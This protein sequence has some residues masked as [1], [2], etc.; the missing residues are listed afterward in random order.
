MNNRLKRRGLRGE[1]DLALVV[2]PGWG[3][4]FE[5]TIDFRTQL[6]KTDYGSTEGLP[7]LIGGI[8]PNTVLGLRALQETTKLYEV[9]VEHDPH[10]LQWLARLYEKRVLP[11]NMFHDKLTWG[12]AKALGMLAA[13][14]FCDIDSDGVRLRDEGADFVEEL[15]ALAIT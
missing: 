15:R 12:S 1:E 7:T 4:K 2:P 6:A 11:P 13:A 8:A 10:A 9:K 14:R 3:D 5:D